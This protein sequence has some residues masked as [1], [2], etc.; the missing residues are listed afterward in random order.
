[1]LQQERTFSN[2]H[3]DDSFHILNQWDL[4]AFT[5]PVIVWLA[6]ITTMV[7]AGPSGLTMFVLASIFFF[8]P[9]VWVTQWLGKMFPRQSGPFM[10]AARTLG[11]KRA[12][13]PSFSIWLGVTIGAIGTLTN[14][15]F[16]LQYFNA[17]WF[18]TPVSESIGIL[19][20]LA[21]VTAVCLIPLQQLRRLVFGST[22]VYL[23]AIVCLFVT[24][25]LW[26]MSG[27]LPQTSF[28]WPDQ[29]QVSSSTIG[30]F[31]LIVFTIIGV[32]MAMS[33]GPRMTGSRS[34]VKRSMRFVW[35][36][37][38]AVIAMYL[39][40]DFSALIIDT[41][42]QLATPFVFTDVFYNMF[43]A[44][45]ANFF[46]VVAVIIDFMIS[47]VY[48]VLLAYV[49]HS[50][51]EH[52]YLPPLFAKT[53]DQHVPRNAI[54]GQAGSIGALVVIAYLILPSV[55]PFGQ[56][57]VSRFAIITNILNASSSIIWGL[58]MLV[59]FLFGLAAVM[60]FSGM[61]SGARWP[62][63]IV[64]LAGIPT[65]FYSFWLTL[66]ASWIPTLIGNNAWFEATLGVTIFLLLG[67]LILGEILR[68]HG[69]VREQDRL[70]AQLKTT[71]QQIDA[72][73]RNIGKMSYD[74]NSAM[75]HIQTATQSVSQTTGGLAQ[76]VE[77]VAAT[78]LEQ[79]ST[80]KEAT[81]TIDSMIQHT[82]TMKVTLS[83]MIQTMGRLQQQFQQ[84]VQQ[85]QKLDQRSIEIGQIANLIDEIADQTNLLSLN[86]AI[87]AARAGEQGRGFAVVAGEV[88]KLAERTANSVR[89]INGLI[90]HIQS[91]MAE[92][93]VSMESSKS[94]LQSSVGQLETVNS[95]VT[96]VVSS[97]E[98]TQTMLHQVSTVT[99]TNSDSV[100]EMSSVMDTTSQQISA[101]EDSMGLIKDLANQLEEAEKIHSKKSGV[102]QMQQRQSYQERAMAA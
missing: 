2:N 22:M 16:T 3:Q 69:V 28:H 63:F 20:M 93:L 43:G 92:T 1:M 12:F 62:M 24:I 97:A 41:P 65:M 15:M 40:A 45:V 54:L 44:G 72:L 32:N 78:S 73:I 31:G 100:R 53:T 79:V 33:L 8:I 21:L 23:A 77:E 5:V 84:S 27:H 29:W 4:F 11:Y 7:L 34:E 87:E 52:N 71:F 68:M 86:A 91:E 37:F 76:S 70:H 81:N 85:V 42:T 60:R 94:E 50:F 18:A 82:D 99:R 80:L 39:I 25:I 74:A 75:A 10:W 35:W 96:E 83:S 90:H 17:N 101:I 102:T 26:T 14:T 36:V 6:N 64:S 48:V 30:S 9:S 66:T 46:N 57:A 47:V 51:G 67:G 56:D 58:G 61:L 49:L 98:T 55:A 59:L 95:Q 88:R 13:F 19:I 38:A 89:E